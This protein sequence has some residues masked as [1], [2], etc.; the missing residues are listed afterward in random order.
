MC[1]GQ[2]EQAGKD[3]RA[4]SFVDEMKRELLHLEGKLQDRIFSKKKISN[5]RQFFC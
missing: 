3:Q 5:I 2:P 4:V 1:T